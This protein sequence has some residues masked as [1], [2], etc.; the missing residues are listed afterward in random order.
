MSSTQAACLRR[1]LTTLALLASAAGFA[2]A[3]TL[4]LQRGAGGGAWLF[5]FGVAGA[6]A[7]SGLVMKR[8]ARLRA[9]VRRTFD[10]W[11][12]QRAAAERSHRALEAQLEGLSAQL[13]RETAE[14]QRIDAEHD[15]FFTLSLDLL[16]IAGSDGL[17]KRVNPAFERILGYGVAETTGARFFELVHPDDSRMTAAQIKRLMAGRAVREFETRVRHRDG[18]YRCITW[19]VTPVPGQ[20]YFHACG[21]DVTALRHAQEGATREQRR[22]RLIF[23]SV[24]VGIA[25]VTPGAEHSHIVN[26]AHERI[27]GITLAESQK[28]GAFARASHPDDYRRQ[29]ECAEPFL[30]GEVD[31]YSVEKRY[32]HP[33]G[34]V[35]WAVLTSRCVKDPTTGLAQCMT[36]LIDITDL[37]RAEE[38]ASAQRA[39]FKFI[40]DS[41]PVGISLLVPGQRETRVVNP[42]H[43]RITGISADHLLDSGIFEQLTHPEDYARQQELVQKYKAGE[44]DHFTLE[45]RYLHPDGKIVWVS[46]ERRMFV[47]P[48]TGRRQSITTLIDI[49]ERKHAEARLAETHRQLL[50]SSRQAGMAEVATGVLHNVGNVLNSVN[51]STTLIGDRVRQSKVANVRKLAE[52]LAEQQHDLA[53]FLTTDPRG[54]KVPAFVQSLAEHLRAEQEETLREVESLRKN[55]EHIKDIVAMQQSYAKV[56][57]VSEAVAVHDLIDDALRMHASGLARDDLAVVR[58]APANPTVTVEKHKVLQILVNLLRNARYACDDSGRADKQMTIRVTEAGGTVRIA[59]IDNGVGIPAENLTRIFS[60]GFTTKKHGHGF[61]LHSG[62]IAAR[63]LG[64][65]LRAHSDGHGHGAAFTLELPLAVERKAA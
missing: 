24:P 45:K 15:G 60:H 36:T 25:L 34:S 13:A 8:L 42:A 28:P 35:V 57:G 62:A 58:E 9:D 41:V 27:T 64:G 10:D 49:T 3:C 4:A 26:P 22:F 65:A 17:L 47:E 51:V 59:V 11:Q 12:A 55:I 38:E 18:S 61:G 31:H 32:L 29:L 54:A 53:R 16:C 5:V 30:R 48:T 2:A 46:L 7:L 19:S 44:I 14:R 20:N 63:E 40:F 1:E 23:E 33:D 6:G 50:E 56:C 43:I 39:R 37:K 52:L 21:R